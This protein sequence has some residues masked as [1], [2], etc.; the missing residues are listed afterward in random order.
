M[1]HS[2]ETVQCEERRRQRAAKEQLEQSEGQ[3][4]V[5]RKEV[6]TGPLCRATVTS[7]ISVA[8]EDTGRDTYRG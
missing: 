5:T 2:E 6:G 1:L 3:A 7:Y 4:T 8:Y